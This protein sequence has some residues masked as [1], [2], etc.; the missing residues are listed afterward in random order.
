MTY[1]FPDS[2]QAR[3]ANVTDNHI[4][5]RPIATLL[6]VKTHLFIFLEN[7]FYSSPF[8][9]IMKRIKAIF[10]KQKIM[11]VENP[12]E[13]LK[14]SDKN[15][16]KPVQQFIEGKLQNLKEDVDKS[17]SSGAAVLSIMVAFL[18]KVLSGDELDFEKLFSEDSL[19]ELLGTVDKETTLSPEQKKQVKQEVKRDFNDVRSETLPEK[20]APWFKEYAGRFGIPLPTAVALAWQESRFRTDAVSS[21]NARGLCQLL[22]ATAKECFSKLPADLRAKFG[23]VNPQ[24][25]FSGDRSRNPLHTNPELNI[26]LGMFYLKEI[27][28]D[29]TDNALRIVGITPSEDERWKFALAGYNNGHNGVAAKIRTYR[30]QTYAQLHPHL[31]E[32]TRNYVTRI[33]AKSDQIAA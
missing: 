21:S 29:T 13:T 1:A 7:R 32:E 20:Y 19:N 14:P 30:P 31:R 33:D 17:D 25:F 18:G 15:P 10:I 12:A 24:D 6:R 9:G 23:T 27:V 22:P 4:V 28:K 26:A 2:G 3:T 5:L 11:S 16:F 8:F